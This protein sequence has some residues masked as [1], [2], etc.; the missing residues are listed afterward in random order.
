MKVT[1]DDIIKIRDVAS[2]NIQNFQIPAFM[3]GSELSHSDK[4]TI[5]W[6]RAV[7]SQFG[8]E[9]NIEVEDKR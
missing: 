4:V 9:F 2:T 3:E 5:S 1:K 7:S 6:I 8:L